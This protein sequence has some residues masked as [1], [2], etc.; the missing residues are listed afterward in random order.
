MG[1]KRGGGK[2]KISEGVAVMVRRNWHKL[3]P[4]E[5][6]VYAGIYKVDLKTLRDCAAGKSWKHLDEP[7]LYKSQRRSPRRKSNVA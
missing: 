6:E 5:K 2:T 4:R 1:I 3:N 7:V